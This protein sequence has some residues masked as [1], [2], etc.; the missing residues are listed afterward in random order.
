MRC[1]GE[2]SGLDWRRQD[3][4]QWTQKVDLKKPLESNP[5]PRDPW[6]PVLLNM[7]AIPLD[8]LLL[9][10]LFHA[11]FLLL[12]THLPSIRKYRPDGIDWEVERV[13]YY[14][15]SPSFPDVSPPADEGKHPSPIQQTHATPRSDLVRKGDRDVQIHPEIPKPVQQIIEQPE[16]KQV[17]TLP[18]LELPNILFQ[19]PKPNRGI[20]APVPLFEI[21]EELRQEKANLP[22][23]ELPNQLLDQPRTSRGI[24]PAVALPELSAELQHDFRR[25]AVVPTSLA[26]KPEIASPPPLPQSAL[27][28]G[29]LDNRS[30]VTD[31]S[32]RPKT[33]LLAYSQD[34]VLPKGE[35]AIPKTR[36]SGS[37]NS[38]SSQT[39]ANA[40]A[41]S[42][43]FGAADITIPNVSIKT[44]TPLPAGTARGMVVQAPGLPPPV[45]E[46]PRE[47]ENKSPQALQDYL[48]SM[49]HPLKL[50]NAK[51]VV[52]SSL[53]DSPLV[54]AERKGLEIYTAAINAPNFTSKRGS[55]VF[56]FAEVSETK[57]IPLAVEDT[58]PPRHS[59]LTAPS[60]TIK[61]DPRYPPEV[62]RDRVEGV[63]I[64]YAVIRR[65]GS[66][67]PR[68]VRILQKL[69]PRPDVSA[70]D[71]LLG[72]KFKPSTKDGDPVDIQA[73]VSIPFYL[74]RDIFSP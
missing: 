55:W 72:W 62:M 64:L 70:R 68:S 60:A 33:P 26:A 35:L 51:P 23:V 45:E 10:V 63:V 25:D 65:D 67:D 58:P 18:K 41:G 39:V 12:L 40:P 24:E 29:D 27:Q 34:P 17:A 16:V 61:V 54:E 48:V 19:P 28:L 57:I 30:T 74:H 5:S 69:D 47:P 42:L 20:E 73:E 53:P 71:A 22:R 66:V 43:D 13:T 50:P 38:T 2:F 36:T 4:I 7:P 31:L 44:Q 8:G 9:S 1:R 49:T 11:L 59:Q 32:A 6:Q 46:K 3:C 37:L 14:R 15:V 21:S 52:P 56:R